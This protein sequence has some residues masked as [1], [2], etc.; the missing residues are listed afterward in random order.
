MKRILTVLVLLVFM[1]TW[2][3]AAGN[4]DGEE[5]SGAEKKVLKMWTTWMSENPGQADPLDDFI[6]DFEANNP[7][8]IIEKTLV[9]WADLRTMITPALNS[10]TGPDIFN[11]TPGPGYVGVMADAGLLLPLDDMV[12]EYSWKDIFPEWYFR[13]HII[14][15]TMWGMSNSSTLLGLYYNKEIF[16]DLGIEIPASYE[17]FLMVCEKL[18]SA[19]ITPVGLPLKDQWEAFHYTSIYWAT[20]AGAENYLDAA[21]NGKGFDQPDFVKAM[22]M[23]QKLVQSGYSYK[24]PNGVAYADAQNEFFAGRTGMLM[25]GTWLN[26]TM[27]LKMGDNVGFFSLPPMEG[28]TQELVGGTG[29]EWIISSK[30]KYPSEVKD[31]L[32][33]IVTTPSVWVHSY[34]PVGKIDDPSSVSFT[35]IQQATYDAIQAADGQAPICDLVFNQQANEKVKSETQKLLAGNIN[36]EEISAQIQLALETE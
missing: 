33:A 10:G 3:F 20:F 13:E 30:T 6:A 11:Y 32:N 15:G 35:T 8:V 4:S 21:Y 23:M 27:D 9:A 22:S 1:S 12:D 34:I 29:D 18:K 28:N 26:T 31:L 14:K 24:D 36:A 2:V 25:T 16:Q 17:E 5:S 19:E 7:G